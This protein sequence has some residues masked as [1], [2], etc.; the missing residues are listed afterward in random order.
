MQRKISYVQCSSALEEAEES[1]PDP[2]GKTMTTLNP[3][4][5]PRLNE[6]GVKVFE[7]TIQTNSEQKQ[8]DKVL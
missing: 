6:A 3:T 5:W 1:E 8:P 4:Q 2:K 7:D